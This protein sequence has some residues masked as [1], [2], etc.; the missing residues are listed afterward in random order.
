MA[1]CAIRGDWLTES[2]RPRSRLA[3]LG[4]SL[5]WDLWVDRSPLGRAFG[6]RGPGLPQMSG[7]QQMPV[8]EARARL[9]FTSGGRH[10]GRIPSTVWLRRT[11]GVRGRMVEGQREGLGVASH[12]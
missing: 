7:R 3:Y 11:L 2:S 8:H 10:G 5:S 4:C 6:L 9:G 1:S 12:S